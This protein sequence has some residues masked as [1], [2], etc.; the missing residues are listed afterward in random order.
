MRKKKKFRWKLP[1]EGEHTNTSTPTVLHKSVKPWLYPQIRKL[2]FLLADALHQGCDSV[3][4]CGSIQSNH[5]RTTAIAA[6]QL[7]MKP[8]LILKWPGKIVSN[9]MRCEV[10]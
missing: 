5:A 2:E 8:H 6:R 10:K 7:G 9:V 4:T 1:P 3:V